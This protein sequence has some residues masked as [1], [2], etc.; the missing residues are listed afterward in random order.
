MEQCAVLTGHTDRVWGVAWAPNGRRLASCSGDK[1]VRVWQRGVGEGQ[2][3][4]CQAVLDDLHTRTVRSVAWSPDGRFLATASFDATTAVWEF[5]DGEWEC[6]ATLE[7][8]DNE[9]KCV[10]WASSGA[11]LATCSR[12]KSVWIWEMEGGE[13][14][15]C[16]AVLPSGSGG[17]TQDV[18]RVLFH[19]QRELLVSCSYDDTMRVWVE[20]ETEEWYCCDTLSGHA[21]TVW[22]VAFNGAGDRLISCSDDRTVKLWASSGG[23]DTADPR[24]EHTA[25]IEGHHERTIF[26]VAWGA[27]HGLVAT[28]C[29]DNTIRVFREAE[30]GSWALAGEGAH[31]RD[32]NSV[33]WAPEAAQ[34]PEG[35]QLL[36]SGGDDHAIRLWTVQ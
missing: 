16:A 36:A 22:G 1:T 14:F 9:V 29:A 3:W 17:H 24:F 18:K 11:L 23:S 19:P 12:D 2:A 6:I 13:D 5:A 32:A 34:R 8:H 31:T 10:A 15:E 33:A 27:E 26:D 21:S 35:A 7:G 20:D 25:T 4:T 30:D 28:A